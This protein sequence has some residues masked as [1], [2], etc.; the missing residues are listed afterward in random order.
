M[1]MSDHQKDTEFLK[2]LIHCEDSEQSRRLESRIC[3][4][5]TRERIVRSAVAQVAVLAA[6]AL[7]GLCY[8]AI[9]LPDFPQNRSQL[10]LKIFLALALA[11]GISLLAYLGVWLRCRFTLNGL[12]DQCR[13]LVSAAFERGWGHLKTIPFPGTTVQQSDSRMSRNQASRQDDSLTPA[14]FSKAA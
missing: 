7:S 5:E 9:L 3:E 4:A 11:S 12:R 10:I 1:H 14:Q 6:L 13:D 8:S 2:R